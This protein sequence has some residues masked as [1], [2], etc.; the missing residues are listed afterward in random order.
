MEYSIIDIMV[1]FI[2][3]YVFYSLV[4]AP[5]NTFLNIRQ[6]NAQSSGQPMKNGNVSKGFPEIAKRELGHFQ[7]IELEENVG[8]DNI[9]SIRI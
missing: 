5:F 9:E 1:T 3:A 4:E 2:L 8:N 7:E 6:T